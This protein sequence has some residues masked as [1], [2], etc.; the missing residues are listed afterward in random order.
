LYSKK[1]VEKEGKSVEKEGEPVEKEIIKIP[2]IFNERFCKLIQKIRGNSEV[3]HWYLVNSS[4]FSKIQEFENEYEVFESKKGTVS[5]KNDGRKIE[6][7]IC[8]FSLEV[9]GK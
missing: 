6:C 4:V 7:K 1:S 3:I 5:M 9:K 2:I 8:D